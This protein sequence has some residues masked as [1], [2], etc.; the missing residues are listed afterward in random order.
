MPS[1]PGDRR[2]FPPL[3]RVQI[4]RIACT[5]PAA[6]GLHLPRW[7]GRSLQDVVVEQLVVGAIH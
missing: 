6:Y 3:A 1:A 4:E 7:D 2:F 5:D